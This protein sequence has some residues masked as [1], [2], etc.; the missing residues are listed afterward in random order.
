MQLGSALNHYIS[1]YNQ[2]T[3]IPVVNP[4]RLLYSIAT[5]IQNGLAPLLTPTSDLHHQTSL[6][7]TQIPDLRHNFAQAHPVG[8]CH[9][10]SFFFNASLLPKYGCWVSKL[11]SFHRPASA[12]IFP[13]C[14]LPFP[15]M[16]LLL[17]RL[18][19]PSNAAFLGP[20]RPIPVPMPGLKPT[21]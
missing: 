5:Q 16:S 12:A 20:D 7:Q 8:G 6:W 3:N 18:L 9:L 15:T 2:Y 13:S 21:S 10:L 1:S 11:T 4:T 17:E 19:D 14:L